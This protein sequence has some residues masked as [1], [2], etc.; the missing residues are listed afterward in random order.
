MGRPQQVGWVYVTH[1]HNYSHRVA[2]AAFIPAQLFPPRCAL[3]APHLFLQHAE[4]GARNAQRGGNNCADV[5]PYLSV[6]SHYTC[7]TSD[8]Q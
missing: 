3:R 2:R 8:I 4:R 1:L 7:C 5:T 6:P